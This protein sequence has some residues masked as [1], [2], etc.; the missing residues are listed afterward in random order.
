[1]DIDAVRKRKRCLETSIA[2]DIHNFCKETGV[3]IDSIHLDKMDVTTVGSEKRDYLYSI[4][5]QVLV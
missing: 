2:V 3:T 5:I 4:D 1:M